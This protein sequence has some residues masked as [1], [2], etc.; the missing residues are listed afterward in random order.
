MESYPDCCVIGTAS[1]DPYQHFVDEKGKSLLKV[2]EI[3]A[4]SG[5]P[6]FAFGTNFLL[7]TGD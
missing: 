5:S 4:A 2:R 1:A 7:G 6:G 3:L